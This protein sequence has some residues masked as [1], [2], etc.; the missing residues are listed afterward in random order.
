MKGNG[1]VSLYPASYTL[2][3]IPLCIEVGEFSAMDLLVHP[4]E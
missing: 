1:S 4:Y 3:N 2:S